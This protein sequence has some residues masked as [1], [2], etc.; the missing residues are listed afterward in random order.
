M[1]ANSPVI[2]DPN[3]RALATQVKALQGVVQVR[4][5]PPINPVNID[6]IG[7]DGVMIT[8]L[9]ANV[10]PPPAPDFV[11]I[12]SMVP[13]SVYSDLAN[14]PAI[15]DHLSARIAD[16]LA[17]GVVTIPVAQSIIPSAS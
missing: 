15:L 11:K 6:A 3:V 13:K 1:T 17:T 4:F 12:T 7:A 14:F 2:D 8:C 9:L 5:Y 16:Y 10:K